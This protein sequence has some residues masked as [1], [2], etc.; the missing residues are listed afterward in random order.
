MSRNEPFF[1]ATL[2]AVALA[3]LLVATAGAEERPLP[4]FQV[5]S[6]EET[7]IAFTYPTTWERMQPGSPEDLY[8]AQAPG[9]MTGLFVY[10]NRE[11]SHDRGSLDTLAQVLPNQLKAQPGTVVSNVERPQICGAPA[12]SIKYEVS[13]PGGKLFGQTLVVLNRAT[14]INFN[15]FTNEAVARYD[16]AVIENVISTIR[17]QN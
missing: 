9:G 3:A 11:K 12:V 8:V 2:I 5:F 10:L 17:C 15:F 4:G 6:D 7:G 14:L 1:K 13:G 16:K